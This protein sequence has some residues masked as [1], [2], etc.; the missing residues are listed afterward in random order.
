[1]DATKRNRWLKKK[2]KAN[3][4]LRP[5]KWINTLPLEHKCAV[6]N[7]DWIFEKLNLG[8]RLDYWINH[9]ETNINTISRNYSNIVTSRSIESAITKH[10]WRF[11]KSNTK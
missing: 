3:G 11:T 4:K 5:L 10:Y 7:L 1:L 8:K 2:I 6:K 9:S